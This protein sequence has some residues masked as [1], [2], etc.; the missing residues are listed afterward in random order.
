MKLFAEKNED[1]FARNQGL[2]HVQRKTQAG[3]I[4]IISDVDEISQSVCSYLTMNNIENHQVCRKN[5]F[6]IEDNSAIRGSSAVIIDI[7]NETNVELIAT[8][9]TL[10]IPNIVRVI[11]IG[12]SDSIGFAQHMKR[13][14][15]NYLHCDHQLSVIVGLLKAEAGSSLSANLMKISLLGC[16]GGVGTSTI[17]YDLFQSLTKLS[18][19][20]TLLVQGNSGSSD[21]DLIMEQVLP[22]DG[23]L[24][25]TGKHAAVR[26]E[27]ADNGWEYDAQMFSRFN[28]II[29]DHSMTVST[30]EQYE[31]VF[32]NS[33]TII[34]IISRNLASLRVAKRIIEEQKRHNISGQLNGQKMIVCLNENEPTNRNNIKNEDIV[35]FLEMPISVTLP[36]VNRK[37]KKIEDSP[38]YNFAKNYILGMSEFKEIKKKPSFFGKFK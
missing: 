38:V 2:S 13:V 34:L 10:L 29:F 25:N 32:A 12:N 8:R 7:G 33:Q 28:L 22:R 23:S 26:I 30:N 36:Y 37:Y 3:D 31:V 21:L 20:P 19:I 17:A 24:F 14:G 1:A 15:F 9:A 27:T 35:D 18:S 6:T 11:F 5:F 4:L 16:K